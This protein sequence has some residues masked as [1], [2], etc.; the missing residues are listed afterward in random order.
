MPIEISR[1]WFFAIVGAILG[2]ILAWL[3]SLFFLSP[4]K[5]MR[6]RLE[7]L[8]EEEKE[9]K[10][11]IKKYGEAVGSLEAQL[12]NSLETAQNLEQ[13]LAF[14]A[15]KVGLKG[16]LL[17]WGRLIFL[18]GQLDEAI[19]T[20][21]RFLDLEPSN[22][23]AHFYRGLCHLRKGGV[24]SKKA[25]DDLKVASDANK[26]DPERRLSLAQAY[27]Q[28][29]MPTEAEHQ[30]TKALNLGVA[31]RLDAKVI[32]GRARLA[33]GDYDA[34][35]EIF[36]ECPFR[37]SPAVTGWGEALFEK[38]RQQTVSQD[39]AKV[40]GDI[41]DLYTEAIKISP[42]SSNYYTFRAL[43]YVARNELGDWEKALADW[44]EA[45][46]ISPRDTKPWEYE[47]DA[48]DQRSIN[49]AAGSDRDECLTQAI[50]C[51]GEALKRAPELHRPLLRNKRSRIYQYLGEFDK[52]LTEARSGARE[53]PNY[54]LNFM[55]WATAAISA[56]D[57]KEVI[58]AADAGLQIV[59]STTSNA[60]R[61]W[62]TLFRV[63]GR[64]GDQQ[65][66]RSNM[67]DC[68]NLAAYL[69]RWS[70]FDPTLWIWSV[71]KDRLEKAMNDWP[72]DL[73]S[74]THDS[75]LLVERCLAIDQ[76]QAKHVNGTSVS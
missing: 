33:A 44:Q 38:A 13:R 4:W 3:V 7:G 15:D 50:R 28:A 73:V 23:T 59:D 75:I 60:G 68:K 39:R 24:H 69:E 64:C 51:Y 29:G 53:N 55:A 46:D 35:I 57:W 14:L 22:D 16:D 37:H 31:N 65:P 36:K 9:L 27:Y 52:A 6:R 18:E 70:T 58:E 48:L 72:G 43:A 74:I 32:I 17:A 19:G 30:A 10:E 8:E 66:L 61:I 26:N 47:G 63:I 11:D 40:Y 34:A 56:Y 42:R 12:E 71:A 21:D 62:C 1:E 49:L 67:E 20:F 5:R 45:K 25:V 76:Y 54:V 41:I 2:A